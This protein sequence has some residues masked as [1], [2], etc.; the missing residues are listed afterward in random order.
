MSVSVKQLM[1]AEQMLELP[2]PYSHRYEL[3][4]G[5]LIEVPGVGYEHALLGRSFQLLLH[6]FVVE[7]DL[8]DVFPDSLAYIIARD[9]DVVR[10]PDVSFISKGRIPEEGFAGFVPFAP[11]LAIEIVSPSDR[12]DEVHA[13]VRE[14]IE[15]GPRMVLVLWPTRRSASVHRPGGV[16]RELGPDDVLDGG[17]VLPGF[18]VRVGDLFAGVRQP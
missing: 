1:T 7:R 17:D 13:K 16:A 6:Q 2:E 14:Y 11:D 15:G 3:V 9:P 18:Q 12:A 10:V 5:E 8:G 4:R